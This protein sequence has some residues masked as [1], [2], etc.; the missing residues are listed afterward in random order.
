MGRV[1]FYREA[2][3]SCLNAPRCEVACAEG[4]QSRDHSNRQQITSEHRAGITTR[5]PSLN[6]NCTTSSAM[7]SVVALAQQHWRFR[8]SPPGRPTWARVAHGASSNNRSW[9]L[10]SSPACRS[11]RPSGRWLDTSPIEHTVGEFLAISK[12]RHHRAFRGGELCETP[13]LERTLHPKKHP[14]RLKI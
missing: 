11:V 13:R 8:W 4:P 9:Q 6:Q 3:T 12:F 10:R 14:R 2:T 7:P 5:S 1:T